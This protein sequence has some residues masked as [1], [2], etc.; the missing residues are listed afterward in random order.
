MMTRRGWLWTGFT[1]A[2]RLLVPSTSAQDR[3][4]TGENDPAWIA[5]QAKLHAAAAGDPILRAIL[6]E[7]FRVKTLRTMGEAVY[8]ADVAVDDADSF[9]VSATLGSLYEP[10]RAKIRPMRVQV[11]VGTPQ[12]DN[13]NSIFADYY[14]GTRYDDGSLPLDNDQ[15]ALRTQIWLILDRMYKTAS[16]AIGR[17][18]AALRGVTV[19]DPLN[20]FWPAPRIALFEEPRRI[21][22]S[23]EVWNGR[24]KALS[25]VFLKY[26]G[27]TSSTVEFEVSQGNT[28]LVNTEATAV[29]ANDSITY[30]RVRA[31]QQS[32]DGMALYTGRSLTALDPAKLPADAELKSVAEE[33]AQ[34]LTAIAAAPVGE[35]YTGPVLFSGSAAAQLFA[36]VF[37]F[38]L[39]PQRRPVTEP[40][41][42][43]PMAATELESRLGSKVLPEWM[44]MVDDAT[45]REYKKR[46]LVG[47]YVSDLEGVAPE[48]VN[49]VEK[50]I[51]KTLLTTR[52]PVRGLTRS[53][54]HARL[55]GGFGAKT[56][57][58]SN[59]FV[60]VSKSES[61]AELKSRLLELVKTQSKP[62]GILVKRMDFP[63]A[64]SA[65]ELRRTIMRASRSGAGG[66]PIS[67]P[68]MIFKVFPDGREEL[69]RGMRFRALGT[70][71]FRDILAAG[72]EEYQFDYIENGA[73]MALMGA[74]NFVV[75]CSV[76]APP[77]LFEEL[78]LEPN[79]DDLPKPPV[80][81]PPPLSSE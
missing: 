73:P 61:D 59:L 9:N 24:V 7:L 27:I 55:P 56:A 80:V 77:V 12:L 4:A 5:H 40:G 6:A 21:K 25:A 33:V 13:C 63:S 39:C 71:T 30:L 76:V 64:G 62:Y 15:V 20:D 79:T 65:D 3:P 46:P 29:R 10:N 66:R 2:S 70:R 17:K 50:G 67:T 1:A 11:R 51:L 36:E 34:D 28:Y 31:S 72:N 23:E 57:R 26:P 48:P 16:E 18:K 75:G 74:G 43:F 45:L 58:P 41:R 38:Q 54:G 37:S 35:S 32:A 19:A 69:I 68:S 60:K 78:E 52:T 22:V 81:P 47:H 53:N 14:S 8:Y 49:L 44:D 42:S